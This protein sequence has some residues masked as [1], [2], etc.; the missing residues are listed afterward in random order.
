MILAR[1]S[2]DFLYVLH[3][4]CPQRA[5]LHILFPTICLAG[6][7]FNGGFCSTQGG[8]SPRPLNA[9]PSDSALHDQYRSIN[10]LL[11]ADTERVFRAA[12][13]RPLCVSEGEYAIGLAI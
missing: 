2:Q 6:G 12:G 10:H 7:F 3:G 1:I 11:K 13:I 5:N 8:G 9:G 4:L